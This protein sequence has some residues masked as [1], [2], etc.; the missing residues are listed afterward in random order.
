MAPRASSAGA[1]PNAWCR[2]PRCAALRTTSTALRRAGAGRRCEEDRPRQGPDRAPRPRVG[3]QFYDP[4]ARDGRQARRHPREQHRV[5]P[6]AP[7]GVHDVRPP[8]F[9]ALAGVKIAGVLLGDVVLTR[10]EMTGLT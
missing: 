1:S 4:A 5:L 3:R 9:A 8:A 2:G 7:A 10:D 6:A